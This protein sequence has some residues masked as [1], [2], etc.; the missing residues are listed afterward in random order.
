MT[1]SGYHEA[2]HRAENMAANVDRRPLYRMIDRKLSGQK[3][4]D[5]LTFVRGKRTIWDLERLAV[6][7]EGLPDVVRDG[8]VNARLTSAQVAD[9]R[10]ARAAGAT[11]AAIAGRFGVSAATAYSICAGKTWAQSTEGEGTDDDRD[12]P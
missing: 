3:R 7:L 8:H 9:I 6:R 4:L 1:G 5:A 2:I 11:F 10:A 12:R